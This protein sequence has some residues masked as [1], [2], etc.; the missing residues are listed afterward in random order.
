MVTSHS[1][2]ICLGNS[3]PCNLINWIVSSGPMSLIGDSIS[4]KTFKSHNARKQLGL[5]YGGQLQTRVSRTF[6]SKGCF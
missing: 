1:F 6:E 2:F 3:E 5:L 4:S